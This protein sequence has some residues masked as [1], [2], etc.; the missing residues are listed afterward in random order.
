M[1]LQAITHPAVTRFRDFARGYIASMAKASGWPD[2]L[3]VQIALKADEL[4]TARIMCGEQPN[5]AIAS[6]MAEADVIVMLDTFT[7]LLNQR[8]DP[9][10]AFSVISS[11]KSRG[12]SDNPEFQAA[13]RIAEKE[14]DDALAKG[15]APQ[16]AM[17]CAYQS[18]RAAAQ[19]IQKHGL[20]PSVRT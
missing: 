4:A 15:L 19:I 17:L 12:R 14:F 20:K 10:M 6:A 16:V 1:T 3:A 7:K 2:D 18:G 5:D 9:K 11:Y 13:N 8:N